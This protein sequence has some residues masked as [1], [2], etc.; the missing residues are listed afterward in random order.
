MGS[1]YKSSQSQTESYLT[2]LGQAIDFL[3]GTVLSVVVVIDNSLLMCVQ[4]GSII[5]V[6]TVMVSKIA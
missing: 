1:R 3:L 6:Q 5:R 2:H 4:T